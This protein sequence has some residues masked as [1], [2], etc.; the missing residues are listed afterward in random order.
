MLGNFTAV[1][2]MGSWGHAGEA[3]TGK[4]GHGERR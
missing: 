4:K 2:Y 1:T 3:E